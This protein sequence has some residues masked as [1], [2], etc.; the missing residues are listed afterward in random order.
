MK[1]TERTMTTRIRSTTH[2]NLRTLC[3]IRLIPL[4]GLSLASLY[5]YM[6]GQ[7]STSWSPIVSLLIL[8]V[9]QIGFSWWRSSTDKPISDQEFFF[10]LVADVV[11][12]GLL[13]YLTGGASNPFVSYFLVPITIAAITLPRPYPVLTG[14]LCLAAYTALLFWFIEVP[15]LAPIQAHH[16]HE[17]HQFNMH[18]IGMWLNFFASALLII[19]FVTR[20][21]EAVRVRDEALIRQQA[22]ATEQRL[23]DEQL[24]A[25]ATLAASAAHDLG[26]PLNTMKLIVDDWRTDHGDTPE[27]SDLDLGEQEILASQIKRCQHILRKLTDT[28]R[29]FSQQLPQATTA[30]HYFEDLIDRWLLMRPDTHATFDM[31]DTSG[32]Q[33]VCPHP[34]LAASIHNILNNAA[35]ASPQQVDV[36]LAIDTHQAQLTVRDH[37]AGINLEQVGSGLG[38]SDKAE[39]LG[40]GLFL[41]RAILARH[42]ARLELE[43]HPQGGTLAR[44]TLPLNQPAQET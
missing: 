29:A 41:S 34:S 35:D 28:A 16:L 39:G 24:L 8:F 42:G 37:G 31:T 26:T 33:Q 44:I 22:A 38:K 11:L 5:L 7:W 2:Q 3:L 9:A 20:M 6:A 1:D 32:G 18:I 13:L 43:A 19:W 30:R 15:D 23:Q 25:V 27:K 12:L 36:H 10:Q 4:G 21:A 17:S 14:G 40:L